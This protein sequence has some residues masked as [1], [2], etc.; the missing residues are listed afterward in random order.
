MFRI[1]AFV[2]PALLALV[3]F[4][5][6]SPIDG[7]YGKKNDLSTQPWRVTRTFQ[8]GER[9]AVFA[10]GDRADEELIGVHIKVFDAKGKLV[11][12]DSGSSKLVGDFAGVAMNG[13]KV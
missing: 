5:V 11:A 2:I 12:E 8:G 7:T 3:P 4:G 1:A 6:S 10:L 9:A 13:R